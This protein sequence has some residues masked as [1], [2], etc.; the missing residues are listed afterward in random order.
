MDWYYPTLSALS[1]VLSVLT[2]VLSVPQSPSG[3]VHTHHR[4]KSNPD[5][6]SAH[7][8]SLAEGKSSLAFVVVSLKDAEFNVCKL[9]VHKIK[10]FDCY[11]LKSGWPFIR[12]SVNGK[13]LVNFMLRTKNRN[14]AWMKNSLTNSWIAYKV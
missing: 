3:Q 2:H 11:I 14:F 12:R 8:L 1:S 6:L 13:S 7:N 5:T 9:I 10:G 4:T